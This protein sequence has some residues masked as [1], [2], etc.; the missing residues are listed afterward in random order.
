VIKTTCHQ[1]GKEFFTKNYKIVNGEG[2]YCSRKCL[3]ESQKKQ[4]PMTCERCGKGFH[5]T[6]SQIKNNRKYCSHVCATGLKPKK[7]RIE[8]KCTTCGKVFYDLQSQ[9]K[10]EN[11]FCSVSCRG[12]Y[13][14]GKPAWN[15]GVKGTPNPRKGQ[16]VLT[17]IICDYCGKSVTGRGWILNQKLKYKSH[18]CSRK[19]HG[20]AQRVD[21]KKIRRFGRADYYNWRR[22]VLVRD[23]GKCVLC[24]EE[25]VNTYRELHV[26]HIIPYSANIEKE[27][28]AD[29]GA[30]LCKRHHNLMRNEEDAWAEELARLIGVE[31]NESPKANSHAIK[32]MVKQK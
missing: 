11:V 25:G 29:N 31:L 23:G 26:H 21:D 27:F 15:K 3:G 18:Y 2:K 9:R 6:P 12:N 1:C 22:A 7:P 30:T 14:V 10:T 8:Y 28:D 4:I 24:R 17:T 19:C 5:A 13:L 32:K 16:W 20:L